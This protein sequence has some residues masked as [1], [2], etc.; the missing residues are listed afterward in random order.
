[1]FETWTESTFYARRRLVVRHRN[2]TYQLS[3]SLFFFCYVN[4]V[5][6]TKR[7]TLRATAAGAVL[8]AGVTMGASFVAGPAMGAETVDPDADKILRSMSTYLG[9]LST[10]SATADVDNEII[11]MAGQKLQLSSS[12]S[13]LVERPGKLHA[14][15]RGP[16][17]DVEVIY[18]GKVVTINGKGLNVYA[19]FDSPGTI[20]DAIA[21]VRFE[22]GLDAP[23]ADL[24]YADPYAGLASNVTSG[25]YLGTAYVN[26]V[27]CHHLAYRA[28]KVDWQI[29][30]QAGDKP[31]PMKYVITSKWVTGAPEYSVRFRDW[32][33]KPTIDP[34]LFAFKAPEGA[35][36]LE[37]V[38]VNEIGELAIEGVK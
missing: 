37:E 12:A 19:Q 35:T 4:G 36:K 38:P 17:A 5:E 32:N 20:D 27:E 3:Q 33:T 14:T 7:R 1:M 18:D 13:V 30:V 31:L 10:F 23:G 25:A 21:T 11:D 15:R 24:L 28:P 8:A 26:G 2:Y 34:S 6:M 9:G 16:L 22:T 29:W